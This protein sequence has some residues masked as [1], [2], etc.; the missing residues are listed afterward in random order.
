MTR[1][2]K[3]MTILLSPSD[4][5]PKYFINSR[6]VKAATVIREEYY[7]QLEKKG[8]AGKSN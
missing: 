8:R 4:I 7:R 1:N 2:L 5:A 6:I 3:S